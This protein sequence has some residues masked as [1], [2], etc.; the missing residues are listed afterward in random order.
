MICIN[1]V[2]IIASVVLA[3]LSRKHYSKYKDREGLR[4]SFVALMLGMGHSA[5]TL[6]SNVV[7]LEGLEHKLALQLRKNQIASPE[8]ISLITDRFIARSLA[9]GLGVLFASNVIGLGSTILNQFLG[10]EENI[11]EREEYGGDVI[12][13]EIYYEMSGQEQTIVLNVSPVRLSESEFYAKADTVAS[14]LGEEYFAEGTVISKDIELPLSDSQGVFA[15][16]WESMNPEI[17][18]SRGRI[19][20]QLQQIP[21]KAF[22][23]MT[24]SYYDYSAT[25]EFSVLVG[26]Q[27]KTAEELVKEDI[28][29][30]LSSIEQDT[31]EEKEF[32][33]PDEVGDVRIKLDNNKT[34][35]GS[36]LMLGVLI[37]V[38]TIAISI[39]RLVETGH[40]RDAKLMQEYPFFVDSLWLYIEAGMNIK[41]A[42][43]EYV[44][45]AENMNSLLTQELNYTLNQIDN[46][47][48]EYE[49]YEELGARLNLP[50]YVSLMR[51]ISQNLQMGTKDLRMLMEA[52]VT[53]A[54]EAKKEAAKKLGEEASTKLVFPMI[55]LLVVVM[56]I[57]MTPA[58]VGF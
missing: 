43:S 27:E 37:A 15:I 21:Q 31:V 50:V 6:L 1:V 55:I 36:I 49:S 29:Q 38:I 44:N 28:L 5:W 56:M 4:A 30:S 12:K 11:I 33:L 45:A 32:L 22:L 53:I 14:E 16:S 24:I 57:I 13:E 26:M 40:K 25:Y 34:K 23:R 41:R 47:E 3:I 9:I 10:D 35:S 19:E 42:I 51:H 39:S 7:P 8:G 52:E 2:I 54:L 58:F 20:A 18:S 48:S 17:L 46:G